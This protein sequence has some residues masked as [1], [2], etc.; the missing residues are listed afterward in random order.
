[1]VTTIPYTWFTRGFFGG[2]PALDFINTVDDEGKTRSQEAIP[3]WP[4]VLVWAVKAELLSETEAQALRN[5]GDGGDTEA[6]MQRLHDLR[7][8]LWRTLR[9]LIHDSEI[10]PQDVAGLADDIRWMTAEADLVREDRSL[11]WEP[12]LSEFGTA[13][14][15]ARVVAAAVDLTSRRDLSRLKECG[16]CSGLFLDFGRGVGRKWCRMSSCGNREKVAKF[17]RT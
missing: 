13:L 16:R 6:E 2:H 7:E 12:D 11:T 5:Q 10:D 15:R 8:M 1:M 14:V 17:R 9:C 4:T 3:D